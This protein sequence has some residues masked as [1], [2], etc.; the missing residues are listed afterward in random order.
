MFLISGKHVREEEGPLVS[1][2]TKA[3]FEGN[4][5][6]ELTILGKGPCNKEYAT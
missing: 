5:D 3:V 1:A 6:V 4:K 2:L